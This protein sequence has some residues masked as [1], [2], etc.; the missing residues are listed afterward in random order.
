MR[1]PE[2]LRHRIDA[3]GGETI[4]DRRGGTVRFA[5]VA[6]KPAEAIVDAGKPQKE[7]GQRRA[8]MAIAKMNSPIARASAGKTSH[9]PAHEKARKSPITVASAASA[10]HN[11]SH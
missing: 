2:R 11:L 6:V 4:R 7:Q 10:G 9:R 5:G 8:T 1:L 3:A